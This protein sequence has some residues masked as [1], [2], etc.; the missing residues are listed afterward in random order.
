MAIL[1]THSARRRSVDHAVVH[2]LR[3]ATS[4]A[5]SW[6]AHPL[7]LVGGGHIPL[8]FLHREGQGYT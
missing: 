2:V 1:L 8:L 6:A 3:E 7:E 5:T 4:G